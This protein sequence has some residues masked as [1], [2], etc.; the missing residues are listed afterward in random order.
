M[1]RRHQTISTHPENWA[2]GEHVTAQLYADG[3]ELHFEM[4][5]YDFF[6]A[7]KPV[8]IDGDGTGMYDR[9]YSMQV[10]MESE[11]KFP[12]VKLARFGC[13]RKWMAT[14]G[15]GQYRRDNTDPIA[16]AMKIIANVV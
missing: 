13:D 7:V 2:S 6:V 5:G 14:D 8:S 15:D 10:F 12:T 4:Y 1:R 16:A 9:F 11:R 3:D